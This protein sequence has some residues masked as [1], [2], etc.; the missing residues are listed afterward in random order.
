MH[1][2]RQ[3]GVV[4]AVGTM[5]LAADLENG[6]PVNELEAHPA[7]PASALITAPPNLFDRVADPQNLNSIIP[8]VSSFCD[9]G[10][11]VAQ[12]VAAANSTMSVMQSSASNA[13]AGALLSLG[14]FSTTIKSLSQSISAAQTSAN[15]AVSS[16]SSAMASA[17]SSANAA[18]LAAQKSAAAMQSNA[19]QSAQVAI[20]SAGISGAESASNAIA[21][22]QSSFLQAVA[23]ASGMSSLCSEPLTT[24]DLSKQPRRRWP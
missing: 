19:Q 14:L 23:N 24:A 22:A 10:T 15:L 11:S 21:L 7:G 17:T 18:V 8:G 4:L 12:A 6:T 13:L 16:A 3:L 2:Y 1:L 5:S 9:C 20:A